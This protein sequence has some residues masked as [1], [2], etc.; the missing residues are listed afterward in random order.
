MVSCRKTCT[1]STSIRILVECAYYTVYTVRFESCIVGVNVYPYL[2]TN[3]FA[4]T[5]IFI[6][7]I[8]LVLRGGPFAQTALYLFLSCPIKS[9]YFLP[10]L[11]NPVN[12]IFIVVLPVTVHVRKLC[13]LQ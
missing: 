11:L 8:R 2:I 4:P 13:S 9:T 10:R 12:W 1:V 7:I 5:S 6:Y 3:T